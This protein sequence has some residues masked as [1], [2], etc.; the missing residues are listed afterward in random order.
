ME[1]IAN[2][3]SYRKCN[4][5]TIITSFYTMNKYSKTNLTKFK[6]KWAEENAQKI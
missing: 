2:E 4:G 3:Q 1:R 5:F 6:N